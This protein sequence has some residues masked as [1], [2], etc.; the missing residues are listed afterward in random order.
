[1]PVKKKCMV[2]LRLPE[3]SWSIL[4][5]TLHMDAKA[6]NFDPK[7]RSAIRRA[8]GEIC[9]PGSDAVE[10][11]NRLKRIRVKSEHS[12]KAFGARYILETLDNNEIADALE[13][14]LGNLLASGRI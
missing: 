12:E 5:E 3:E 2:T 7:L 14:A 11:A 6:K 9:Y 13:G 4:E 10:L 1:M 8:L